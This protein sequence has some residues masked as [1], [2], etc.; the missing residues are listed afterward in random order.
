MYCYYNYWYLHWSSWVIIW[1]SEK[2]L[3]KWEKTESNYRKVA[4]HV[5]EVM[6]GIHKQ[7]LKQTVAM[8]H[9]VGIFWELSCFT[10]SAT[11]KFEPIRHKWTVDISGSHSQTYWKQFNA[12]QRHIKNTQAGR[13]IT[14]R[15]NSNKKLASCSAH[16]EQ[17]FTQRL[18]RSSSV[19]I[20][21][22]EGNKVTAEMIQ[23]HKISSHAF[24]VQIHEG[25]CFFDFLLWNK[26]KSLIHTW[27]WCWQ[28]EERA[29]LW[30]GGRRG[31]MLIEIH[32]ACRVSHLPQTCFR[33]CN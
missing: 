29:V 32:E 19:N 27:Q 20:C 3:E 11:W 17:L 31:W 13:F 23:Q 33:L 18:V 21:S 28:T 4:A 15:R 10:L 2:N 8:K 25:F 7:K 1:S 6:R 14:N 12:A 26:L 30:T 16:K 22:S 5:A 9:A 24:V